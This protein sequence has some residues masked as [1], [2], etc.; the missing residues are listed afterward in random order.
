MDRCWANRVCGNTKT[1]ELLGNDLREADH[2]SLRRRINC[3]AFELQRCGNTCQ[4]YYPTKLILLHQSCCFPA[5]QKG[6]D[7]IR[8]EDLPCL[9][10]RRQQHVVHG[11]DAG[12]IDQDIEPSISLRNIGEHA[13]YRSLVGDTQ[14]VMTVTIVVEVRIFSTTTD[15]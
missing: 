3:L 4:V 5:H 13:L 1:R 7:K 15:N 9:F 2:R 10:Y 11:S 6:A 8:L 14:T 12:V